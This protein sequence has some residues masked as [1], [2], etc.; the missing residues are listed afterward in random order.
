M[1][2]QLVAEAQCTKLEEIIKLQQRHQLR[3]CIL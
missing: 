2:D 3:V 1:L